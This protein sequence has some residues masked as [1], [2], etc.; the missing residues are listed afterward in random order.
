MDEG[1][2]ASVNARPKVPAA[3]RDDAGFDDARDDAGPVAM[4]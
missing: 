2:V 1:F 3:R 4:D